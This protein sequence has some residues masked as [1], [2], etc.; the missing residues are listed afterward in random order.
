MIQDVINEGDEKLQ[1]LKE[2]GDDAYYAVVTAL[3]EINEYNPVRRCPV[4]ELWHFK[5]NRKA[6]LEEAVRCTVNCWKY[7]RISRS[8]I[9]YKF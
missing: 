5:E 2:L 6:S 7:H 8:Y 9:F 1:Y 3:L 4:P